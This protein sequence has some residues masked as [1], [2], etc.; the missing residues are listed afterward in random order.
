VIGIAP[1]VIG[2]APSV[3]GIAPSVIGIA[4]SVSGVAPSVIGIAPSVIGIAPS[5]IAV[6]TPFCCKG[7][8]CRV[9]LTV[10]VNRRLT[11]LIQFC[12][13]TLYSNVYFSL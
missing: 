9:L 13:L 10:I 3:I 4:P 1:S 11:D 12:S 5:V 7:N 8:Y 2:I 6:T